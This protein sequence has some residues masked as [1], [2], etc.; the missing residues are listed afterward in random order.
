[1]S[2][3]NYSLGFELWGNYAFHV[4]CNW[5]FQIVV[6]VN[7]YTMIPYHK[8]AAALGQLYQVEV[9]F[10]RGTHRIVAQ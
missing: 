10:V 1:M 8:I 7:V 5:N 3:R 6:V 9:V 2:T 4:V